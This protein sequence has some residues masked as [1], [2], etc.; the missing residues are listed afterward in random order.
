M[1]DLRIGTVIITKSNG[2]YFTDGDAFP[3][4]VDRDAEAYIVESYD[5]D[6]PCE[7]AICDLIADGI[8]YKFEASHD[9]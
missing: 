3:C 1:Q 5:S 7:H 8:E 4:Y 9:N 2:T 6:E